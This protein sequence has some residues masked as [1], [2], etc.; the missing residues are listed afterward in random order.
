VASRSTDHVV[1]V[2]ASLAGANAAVTLRGEGF[3]G[4][5]TLVGREDALPYGRPP[6]S[7]N[8]FAW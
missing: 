5:I 7:K 6:L 2:G 1:I 8:V 3:R 4:G